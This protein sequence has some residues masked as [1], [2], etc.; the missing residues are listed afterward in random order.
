MENVANLDENSV[1]IGKPDPGEVG[2][3]EKETDAIVKESESQKE[4]ILSLRIDLEKLDK[5]SGTGSKQQ[6]HRQ[7]QKQQQQQPKATRIDPKTEKTGK[8]G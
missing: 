5:D 6:Q 4:R 3:E 2:S 8:P 7:I 1:K